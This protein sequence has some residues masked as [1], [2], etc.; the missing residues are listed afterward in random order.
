V[1]V[2]PPIIK[3][4]P[5]CGREFR[6]PPSQAKAKFCGAACWYAHHAAKEKVCQQCG[7]VFRRNGR[8]RGTG[9]KFCSK[10]CGGLALRRRVEW[11][12]ADC[13]R[14]EVRT[15]FAAGKYL[16]CAECG[17]AYRAAR[18]KGK[19]LPH[20]VDPLVREKWLEAVRTP[21]YRERIRE[22]MTG[23]EMAT[24]I[25]RRGSARHFKALHFTV[26]TPAGVPYRVDNLAEF[27]RSHPHL[28]DPADVVD[29]SRVR[30]SYQSRATAGLAKLRAVVGTRLSWKGW[31]LAFGCQDELGRRA[32]AVGEA[33]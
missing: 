20:V 27:V 10:A 33:A 18:L 5:Q 30:A 7:K 25:T 21:E 9:G 23:R 17:A 3:T 14:V 26:R 31:T 15:P 32:M 8:T 28:F 19:P 12:C 2:K 11:R 22:V 29:R 6:R 16:R 4:C 13:G 24:E 1:N